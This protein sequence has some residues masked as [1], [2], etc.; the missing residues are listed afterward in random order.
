MLK[1]T[2]CKSKYYRSW[3]S[4]FKTEGFQKNKNEKGGVKIPASSQ[5][6][7]NTNLWRKK[8]WTYQEKNNDA[9]SAG[10]NTKA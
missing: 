8:M 4:G 2:W 6:N 3:K 1:E 9:K 10:I 7:F 5:K